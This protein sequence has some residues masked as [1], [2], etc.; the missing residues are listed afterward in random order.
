MLSTI[1]FVPKGNGTE[2]TVTWLPINAT[3]AERKVFDAGHASMQGGWGGTFDQ[4]AAYLA[5]EQT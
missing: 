2:V 4:F 3:E 5:D 1:T